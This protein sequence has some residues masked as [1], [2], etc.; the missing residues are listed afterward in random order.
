MQLQPAVYRDLLATRGAGVD[1]YTQ[2]KQVGLV[3]RKADSI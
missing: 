3:I 2:R 1:T